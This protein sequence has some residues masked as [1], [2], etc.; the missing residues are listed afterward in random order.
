MFCVTS[1]TTCGGRPSSV[2]R[3]APAW[4]TTMLAVAAATPTELTVRLDVPALVKT[5]G[6]VRDAWSAPTKA[7][8][9]GNCALGSVEVQCT[10]PRK[11]VATLPSV[12]SAVTVGVSSV[13][14]TVDGG[15]PARTRRAAGAGLTSVDAEPA[16]AGVTVSLAGNDWGPAVANCRLTTVAPKDAG[17]E[18]AAGRR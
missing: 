13:P 16:I 12:S 17:A 2:S 9:T 7:K 18:R 3:A 8:S 14:A 6:K 4:R 10:V 1:T 15:T 5:T 11:S